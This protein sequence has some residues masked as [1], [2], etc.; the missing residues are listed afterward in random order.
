MSP[1]SPLWTIDCDA[2]HESTTVCRCS[3]CQSLQVKL[4]DAKR[5]IHEHQNPR[6]L[7]PHAREASLRSRSGSCEVVEQFPM[8]RR[9]LDI[10]SRSGRGRTKDGGSTSM[11][12]ILSY[13]GG[14]VV[15]PMSPSSTQQPAVYQQRTY[16]QQQWGASGS[17]RRGSKV[18]IMT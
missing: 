5:D 11:A 1:V 7:Q 6:L 2:A 3:F 10:R 17:E 4:R 16:S 18:V 14:P 9:L 15:D 8:P 12:A 13:L